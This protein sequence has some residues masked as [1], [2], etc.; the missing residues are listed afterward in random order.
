[1][2]LSTVGGV[3]GRR[4]SLTIA[5]VVLGS[6]VGA[7]SAQACSCAQLAPRDAMRQADAAIVA[8]LVEVLPRSSVV[9]DYRYEVRRVYK[10]VRRIGRTISVRSSVSSGSCGLPSGIGR[11]FGLFLNWANGRWR[12]S[13]CGVIPPRQ[14]RAVAGQRTRKSGASSHCDS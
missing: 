3:L 13:L 8:E 4:F 14:L 9:A 5:V 2:F 11:R 1:M 6:A 10:S 12:G 7:S